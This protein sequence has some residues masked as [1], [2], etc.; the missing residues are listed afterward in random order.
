M[1]EW[2]PLRFDSSKWGKTGKYQFKI[3]GKSPNKWV[4]TRRKK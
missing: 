3:F 4:G 2:K 1:V